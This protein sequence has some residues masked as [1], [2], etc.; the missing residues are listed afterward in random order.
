MQLKP[1]KNLGRLVET[2]IQSSAEI[3]TLVPLGFRVSV[4]VAG[5]RMG[6]WKPI[7]HPEINRGFLKD[8]KMQIESDMSL[9]I[10]SSTP[11]RRRRYAHVLRILTI[12]F[13]ISKAL[14]YQPLIACAD[15]PLCMFLQVFEGCQKTSHSLR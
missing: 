15:F 2:L 10:N 6:N 14:I 7:N 13:N 3:Y 4:P 5:K 8:V 12:Y 11:H 1:A 9:S